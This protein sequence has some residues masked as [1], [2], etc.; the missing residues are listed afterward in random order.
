MLLKEVETILEYIEKTIKQTNKKIYGRYIKYYLEEK[1]FAILYLGNE[2]HIIL[3][4]NGRFNK[5]FRKEFKETVYPSYVINQYHWNSIVLNREIP[6]EV[7]F[8]LIDNS[9]SE[10]MDN[11]TRRQKCIY[12]YT[13]KS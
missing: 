6:T 9:I 1:I 10:V 4:A 12:S 2:P 11:M 13:L 8:K 3:K 5:E 7:I